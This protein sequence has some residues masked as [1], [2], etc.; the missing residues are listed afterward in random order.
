M[1]NLLLTTATCDFET[2][3]CDWK[4][5]MGSDFDLWW[6]NA[7]FIKM[8]STQGPAYDHNKTTTG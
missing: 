1:K 4:G 7:D 3:Y 6:V 5:G 8:N 2:D